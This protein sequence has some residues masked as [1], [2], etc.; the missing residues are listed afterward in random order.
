[1]P[2]TALIALYTI[3]VLL[4]LILMALIRIGSKLKGIGHRPTVFE[5]ATME[6]ETASETS[7][8]G[9]FGKFL[10]ERPELLSLKKRE[11]FAA[12]RAWRKEQGLNWEGK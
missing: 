9:A 1:M 2:E 12:F 4:V 10:G 11:Q 3:I 7:H 5:A 8:D 6:K